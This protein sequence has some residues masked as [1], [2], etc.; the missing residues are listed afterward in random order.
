MPLH[1]VANSA[2]SRVRH[3]MRSESDRSP[4][5]LDS[6]QSASAGDSQ[7]RARVV[8][9]PCGAHHGTHV[10]AIA[11]GHAEDKSGSGRRV[12]RRRDRNADLSASCFDQRSNETLRLGSRVI[13]PTD[14]FRKSSHQR[15][16]DYGAIDLCNG[17]S[18]VF[19]R[20]DAETGGNRNRLVDVANEVRLPTE[21]GRPTSALA[22]H[23]GS[24]K[25]IDESSAQADD[26]SQPLSAGGRSD[27]KRAGKPA[28]V[29]VA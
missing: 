10:A 11:P 12:H 18:H 23:A 28:L 14:R 9:Y 20:R 27:E 16:S 25:E 19:G 1:A 3:T 22:C 5:S 2:A 21:V 26:R 7:A 17:G 4:A 15:R 13:S 8:A 29:A 6:R 24:R